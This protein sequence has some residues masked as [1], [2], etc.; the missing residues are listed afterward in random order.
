MRLANKWIAHF[1]SKGRFKKGYWLMGS[2]GRFKNGLLI[3]GKLEIS[4]V[5]D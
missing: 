1:S 2:K 3:N 5:M 4:G